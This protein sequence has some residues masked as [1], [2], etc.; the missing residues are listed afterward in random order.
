MEGLPFIPFFRYNTDMN[1]TQYFKIKH[2]LKHELFNHAKNRT[3]AHTLKNDIE[4][5]AYLGAWLGEKEEPSDITQYAYFIRLAVF[6]FGFILGLVLL[7]YN[8]QEPVNLIYYFTFAVLFP[9]LGLFVSVY[10]YVSKTKQSFFTTLTKKVLHLTTLD[11]LSIPTSVYKSF[12]FTLSLRFS[13]YYALGILS[14]LLFVVISRDIAFAWSM[15][16][17]LRPVDIHTVTSVISA[18]WR[19]FYIDAVPNMEL[20]EKSRYFRLGGSLNDTMIEHAALLGAWWKFLA[21]AVLTYAVIPRVL[22]L[23][24][25]VFVSRR[26]IHTAIKED[27]AI[28]KLLTQFKEPVISSTKRDTAYEKTTLLDV[29]PYLIRQLPK[30][31]TAS[32]YLMDEKMIREIRRNFQ[33]DA[34]DC[35]VKSLPCVIFIKGWEPPTMEILDYLQKYDV[36]KLIIYLVGTPKSGYQVTSEDVTIWTDKLMLENMP[37]KVFYAS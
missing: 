24:V 21:M 20:I 17:A 16:L 32:F 31:Y 23:V 22:A 1:D 6:V 2:A 27:S 10:A 26:H 5:E 19:S 25:M 18:P 8:G 33:I 36:Q 37:I 35:T 34:E 13:L 30:E 11:T 15:T 9:F 28:Q 29:N 3:F 14:A 7:S 4:D 12:L